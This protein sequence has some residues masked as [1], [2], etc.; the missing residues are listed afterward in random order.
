MRKRNFF[1]NGMIYILLTLM[2]VVTLFPLIYTIASAF[3]TNMEILTEP[4]RIL[5]K[6][7]TFD[8]FIQAWNSDSFHVPTLLKNSIIYTLCNVFISIM[9]AS[10]GGYVFA[11]GHFHFKRIIFACF[12]CLMFIKTG[13]IGIYA[14]FK[15]LSA[16][17][18]D[19]SLWALIVM[20]LFSVP[21]VNFY[22]VRGNVEMIPYEIDEAAKIDGCSFIGTFFKII[23]P[24]MKPILATI[25]ILSFNSS[26]ND[27]LMPNIFTLTDPSQRT[28]IVGLM[29]LKSSGEA[30]S[31]WNLMLAGATIALIPVLVAFSIGNKFFVKGL[32]AGAVKG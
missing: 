20:H 9:L 8:N 10:M 22:L 26:W 24:L 23:L 31:S 12:T 15:V 3:K 7:P 4:G 29:A 5:P 18:L 16:V 19:R 32:A 1:G 25:A 17:H 28:L 14:Q 2:L 27:Y 6:A 13:G 11:R 21:I 30:A